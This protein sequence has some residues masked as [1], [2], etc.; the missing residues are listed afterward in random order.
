VLLLLALK[1]T[2]AA[3]KRLDDFLDALPTVGA[4]LIRVASETAQLVRIMV[5]RADLAE[6][7]GETR[8]AQRWGQAVATLWRGADPPL[9]KTVEHMRELAARSGG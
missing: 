6:K 1:D 8:V 9:Q 5:L 3:V 7:Q 2:A 4:S